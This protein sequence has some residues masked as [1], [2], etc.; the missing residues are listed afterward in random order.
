MTYQELVAE[1]ERLSL[2]ERLL[3]IERLARS[4][5]QELSSP[6][7]RELSLRLVRGMLKP[8]GPMPTDEELKEDYTNDLMQ[9]YGL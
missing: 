1:A 7:H 3:L 9:K 6:A 8:D 5:R 4:I 2:D